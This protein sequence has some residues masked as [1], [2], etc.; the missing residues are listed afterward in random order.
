M[1]FLNTT[2]A[3]WKELSLR[4]VGLVVVAVRAGARVGGFGLA[5]EL[6]AAA[7]GYTRDKQQSLKPQASS[8]EKASAQ[9]NNCC[10]CNNPGT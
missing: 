10:E 6:R 2:R 7:L 4:R 3:C 5:S 1:V 8:R 9:H